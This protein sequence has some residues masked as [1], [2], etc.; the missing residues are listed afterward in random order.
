MLNRAFVRWGIILGT[1]ALLIRWL[2]SPEWIE[3]HY[4]RG[5]FP[6]LRSIWDTV[7]T[8]WFP[9]ALLYLFLLVLLVRF[10][11]AAYRW[12]RLS[13]R[14]KLFSFLGGL[15]GVTGWV[16]F[17]FLLVWG[18]NYG[19]IPVED[20]LGLE[21]AQPAL[22]E[23]R[24]LVKNNAAELAELRSRIANNSDSTALSDSEFPADTEKQLRTA[25]EKTLAY[26]NYPT[27][28]AVRGRLLRPQGIFLRFGSAGLYFPWTGEGHID[29]GLL[30]LQ[31]PY[32]MT[33]E[34]AHG[35]G[36]GDEG[37]CSFW[38]VLASYRLN[39]PT[40]I[41]AIRLGYWRRLASTWLRAEPE[42]YW[43]FRQTLPLGMQADLDAIAENNDRY[44][45]IMPRFRDAAYDQYLKAQGI[46]EGMLNYS[47]VVSMVEAW[48]PG[49]SAFVGSVELHEEIM[50][51]SAVQNA[52]KSEQLPEDG[53]YVY[54]VYFAEWGE[55]T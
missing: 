6:L 25:L 17:T 50:L 20:K 5:F 23:L 3:R 26:Y 40:L 55:K 12:S 35:Y 4:S 29:A 21:L 24:E 39:D 49:A 33:H 11:R 42:A 8:S 38:A 34:L 43:T 46:P 32:T 47:K 52:E 28:G 54:E 41:Y 14:G 10:V 13:V 37:T 2:V 9:V 18:L 44:P 27:V 48:R 22:E 51:S 36:F 45:D 7:V 31:Q 16:V 1:T 53:R 19:R 15:M 30:L